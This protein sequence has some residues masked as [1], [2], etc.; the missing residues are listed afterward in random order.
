MTSGRRLP[1]FYDTAL[2]Y[3]SPSLNIFFPLI[4]LKSTNTN[5]VCPIK[6]MDSVLIVEV[7]MAISASDFEDKHVSILL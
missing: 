7:Y 6:A 1:F 4:C 5:H 3:S 2:E